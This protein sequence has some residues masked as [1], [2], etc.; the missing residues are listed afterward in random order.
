MEGWFP[1]RSGEHVSLPIAE[2][3]GSRARVDDR[4]PRAWPADPAA[5]L[6]HPA[7]PSRLAAG[8]RAAM[9]R[10]VDVGCHCTG[11]PATV[12]VSLDILLHG[13]TN[14]GPPNLGGIVLP[15]REGDGSGSSRTPSPHDSSPGC[16][17]LATTARQISPAGSSLLRV[18]HAI[19]SGTWTISS[20]NS[21]T[22]RPVLPAMPACAAA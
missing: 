1:L 9:M 10:G 8:H 3:A 16:P 6:P 18:P 19:A 14:E 22:I 5:A 17:V 7:M 4:T 13:R 12:K 15:S 2:V 21:A 20:R 11:M